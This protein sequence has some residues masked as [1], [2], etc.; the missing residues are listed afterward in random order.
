MNGI[1]LYW[2]IHIPVP[3]DTPPG[4]LILLIRTQHDP[5]IDECGNINNRAI[6][7][8]SILSD[9]PTTSIQKYD[10]QPTP[11]DYNELKP[12]LGWV[13]TEAIKKKSPLMG[14]DIY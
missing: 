2:I 5:R 9:T 10:Q 1:L 3:V 13:N 11:I 12:Y 7:T 8:L 6:H 4:P 14:C